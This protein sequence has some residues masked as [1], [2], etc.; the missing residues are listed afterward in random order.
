[1]FNSIE[2]GAKHFAENLAR[3]DNNFLEALGGYNGWYRGMTYRNA[4]YYHDDPEHCSWQQNLD[5]L[6]QTLNGWYQD[7]SPYKAGLGAIGVIRTDLVYEYVRLSDPKH[8]TES[9]RLQQ[10]GQLVLSHIE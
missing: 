10:L 2:T 5:Y 3:F 1:M 6:E 4:T 9:C 7:I 8:C